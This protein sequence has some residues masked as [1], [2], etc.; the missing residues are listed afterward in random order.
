[1]LFDG[2]NIWVTDE[3]NLKKLSNTGA[4][5]QTVPVC[6]DDAKF[7]TFDGGRIWVP[8]GNDD[9]VAVVRAST[10][11]LLTT[12]TGN[13]LDGAYAAAFD[14]ERVLVTSS[15]DRV[16]LWNAA[17]LAPLGFSQLNVG[18]DPG[19]VCSDGVNF[20]VSLAGAGE[21]VRY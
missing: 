13:G 7:P 11:A 9:T 18:D 19:G 15:G 16:S 2:A 14:G 20:W 5:L 3:G 6:I 1:M 10:G 12:L 17:D 8:C 4:I 21:L